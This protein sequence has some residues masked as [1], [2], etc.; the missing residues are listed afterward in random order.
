[1]ELSGQW[2]KQISQ[3]SLTIQ[4]DELMSKTVTGVIREHT[5]IE[6]LVGSL[7]NTSLWD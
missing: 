6:P 5:D 4:P 1:M 7:E 3:P 2:K